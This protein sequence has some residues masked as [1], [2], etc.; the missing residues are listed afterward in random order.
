[1]EF[2]HDINQICIDRNV[3]IEVALAIAQLRAY[4]VWIANVAQDNVLTNIPVVNP[5]LVDFINS[6]AKEDLKNPIQELLDDNK[7]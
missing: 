4:E 7:E 6:F 2:T 5:A 1:M 3:T